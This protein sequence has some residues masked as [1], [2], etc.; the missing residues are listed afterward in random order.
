MPV[1]IKISE[2]AGQVIDLN[3]DEI[4]IGRLPTCAIV[5]DPHGVSRE[6]ACIRRDGANHYLVDLKSRNKTKV[7]EREIPPDPYLHLLREGDRI[8][9]CD[10]EFV[11]H[12]KMPPPRAGWAD[13]L[14]VTEGID[15]STL[16]TL[17]ASRSDLLAASVRPEAKLRAI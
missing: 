17:D 2:P 12:Q 3:V 10:V 6:H 14:I 7:N 5:L 4:V 1:L 15:D 8:N 13:D 16:H 11:F 9:I